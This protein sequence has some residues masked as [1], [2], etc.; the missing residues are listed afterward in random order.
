MKNTKMKTLVIA[1]AI[2]ILGVASIAAIAQSKREHHG[3]RGFGGGR[4]FSQLDLTD[5][6]KAS[7]KKIRESHSETLK[8]L[9]QQVRTEMQALHQAQQGGTFD[10]AQVSQKL[11]Q[12]APLRAK[13]MAEEFKIRQESLAVLTAEQKAKLD[14][15]RQQFKGKSSE[16]KFRKSQS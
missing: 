10:E 9:H 12:I 11:A 2:A 7:M 5:E 15:L 1:L 3:G 4:M 6:Q 13:L 8:A 14:S 16:R